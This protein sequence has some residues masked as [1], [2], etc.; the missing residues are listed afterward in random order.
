M[1]FRLY[2]HR[3]NCDQQKRC[4]PNRKRTLR[5]CLQPIHLPIQRHEGSLNNNSATTVG[6]R[7]CA[8]M[9]VTTKN[10]RFCRVRTQLQ[11]SPVLFRIGPLRLGDSSWIQLKSLRMCCY[12]FPSPNKQ[13]QPFDMTDGTSSH[14]TNVPAEVAHW[15]MSFSLCLKAKSSSL[16]AVFM[17]CCTKTSGCPEEDCEDRREAR[18]GK[19]FIFR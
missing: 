17:V 3:L 6:R 11:K 9:R 2:L 8:L 15:A 5:P 14:R 12:V 13:F 19:R 7:I 16:L 4:F 18:N 10:A 1:T